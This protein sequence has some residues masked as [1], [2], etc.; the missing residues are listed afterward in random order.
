MKHKPQNFQNY[1]KMIYSLDP[2]QSVWV[3]PNTGEVEDRTDVTTKLQSSGK[4]LGT[5]A[6]IPFSFNGTLDGTDRYFIGICHSKKYTEM[7]PKIMTDYTSRF[8]IIELN[9]QGDI[10]SM[11]FSRFISYPVTLRPSRLQYPT[12]IT[13]STDAFLVSIGDKDCT[14][15]V[16]AFEKEEIKNLFQ[17]L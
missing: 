13:E 9:E 6:L 12:T 1:I 14:S 11:N 10:I 17:V 5:S 4:T 16:I 15:H 8:F 3:D 2:L 7:V